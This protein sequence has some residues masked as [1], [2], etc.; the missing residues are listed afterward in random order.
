MHFKKYFGI[1]KL[2]A[3]VAELA[4]ALDLGSS[5]KTVQVQ[6]LSPA[7]FLSLKGRYFTKK[8]KL[9]KSN[10]E[11]VVGGQIAIENVMGVEGL[12]MCT[13]APT[14]KMQMEY[15]GNETEYLLLKKKQ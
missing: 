1:I 7:P 11:N 12:F 13:G 9:I 6:V 4:D 5:G 15:F 2:D 8:A 3:G 10:L 14:K